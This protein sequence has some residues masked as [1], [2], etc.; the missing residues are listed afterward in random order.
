MTDRQFRCV[1]IADVH[2]RGLS[3]HEQYRKS[4]ENFFDQMAEVKPD[5][6]FVGGDIVHSKTQGIS[7]ELI[8]VLS[9]WFRGLAASAPHVH[10]ILGNHDGLLLNKERQDAI[11]PILSAL[12]LSNVY[13]HKNSGTYKTQIPGFNFCVFSC[14]DED[15]WKN[16]KPV[17]GDVNIACF[18]GSVVGSLTD[19]DWELEGEVEASFFNAFDFAFLGDIHRKQFLGQDNRIAYCGSTI[20]QNFGESPDKGYLLWEIDDKDNFDVSFHEVENQNRFV[21]IDWMGDVQ[22]T[23]DHAD[24]PAGSQVRVQ[25]K[26]PIQQTSWLHLRNF[27][28]ENYGV[29]ELVY[30][31]RR[32][33]VQT[34]DPDSSIEESKSENFRDFGTL[35]KYMQS[36]LESYGCNEDESERSLEY[37][38]KIHDQ[39]P[40]PDCLRDVRWSIDSMDFDN[41]YSYG[42]GN[43]ID[44][45]ALR[46]VVGLFGKN[47][48]GK[49]S[50]PGTLMYGLFNGS[51]RG[52]IKNIHIVNARKDHCKASIDFT[53]NGKK[54][55]VERQSVKKTTRAGVKHAVTHMN[56]F[57]L[58]AQGEVLKDMSEEQ[59][60]E[61]EKIVRSL[62]GTADN[63][64]LTSFASQG[65]MNTFIK[66]RATSRKAILTSFLDFK[67][68]EELNKTARQD[69]A[70]LKAKLS[71]VRRRDF[72]TVEQEKTTELTSLGIELKECESSKKESNA[73]LSSVQNALSQLPSETITQSDVDAQRKKIKADEKKITDTTEEKRRFLKLWREK[74]E[75]VD[76]LRSV[77]ANSNI[78]ELRNKETLAVELERKIKDLQRD[79]RLINKQIS[80]LDDPGFLKGCKCLNEAEEAL[81]QKPGV[82]DNISDLT[83]KYEALDVG[84]LQDRIKKIEAIRKKV[85]AIDRE[86][87]SS[88]AK[89]S[90]YDERIKLAEER[91]QLNQEKLEKM[92]KHVTDDPENERLDE[93]KV[94]KRSLESTIRKLDSRCISLAKSIGR[95]Q[96]EIEQLRIERKKFDELNA[97]WR[98][99]EL[100]SEAVSKKGIPLTVLGRKLPQVNAEIAQILQ[101]CT[102]FTVELEADQDSNA[103]DVYIN[104]GDSR[105][106]I[107]CASGMEKMMA[108]LAI[109]VALMNLTTLPRCDLL[110]IDEGFGA[111]DENNVEACSGL[112]HNLKKWFKSILV[113]SHV[114]AVKDSVDNVIEISKKGQDS[115]VNMS[116]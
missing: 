38:K 116:E 10:I 36:W 83:Q 105:R 35:S 101:G 3:R 89:S 91:M 65:E 93:L 53:V 33:Q 100:V 110:I 40:E 77:I 94:E 44:F 45:N 14:F 102:G 48:T 104:Y 114:D 17:P 81:A 66:Q 47:R 34:V 97:E 84:T 58:N 20:Q 49:S 42:S 90:I 41:M 2:F 73:K 32:D 15:G 30:D 21:T 72:G 1:H 26:R 88:T 106:I 9:W 99:V 86:V 39:I 16:I 75:K 7:P 5:V 25:S 71:E 27:M 57:Q 70:N 63:F 87:K 4:F 8:D 108:S 85:D 80:S 82:E 6:I 64:L 103:M 109:R 68:F 113:I 12:N 74:K 18:H 107:E 92:L 22:S 96:S 52:A 95:L 79:L 28:K 60:R 13:L 51:D 43:R 31:L 50:I 54:Y 112:L 55:R 115:Y 23:L 11:T 56:C 62:I 24:I 78:D 69:L 61:T 111:L 76:D 67:I 37:L 29:S 46:G 98:V 19:I 59:R